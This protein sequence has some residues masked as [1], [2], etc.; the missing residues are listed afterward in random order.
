MKISEQFYKFANYAFKI[1]ISN[2]FNLSHS[3]HINLPKFHENMPK[4]YKNLSK[5]EQ[6]VRNL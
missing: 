3:F 1:D 6:N 2:N 5:F 4:F